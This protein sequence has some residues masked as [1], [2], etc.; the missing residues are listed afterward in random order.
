MNVVRNGHSGLS[1]NMWTTSKK[2]SVSQLE[3]WGLDRIWGLTDQ[4]TVWFLIKARKPASGCAFILDLQVTTSKILPDQPMQMWQARKLGC[5]FT[6]QCC[7]LSYAREC[8]WPLNERPV[9]PEWHLNTLHTKWMWFSY[10]VLFICTGN[11]KQI[12]LPV[13]L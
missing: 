2:I 5:H 13:L 3:Q 7:P 9:H 10:A 8:V 1:R 4:A 12:V 6:A 11:S